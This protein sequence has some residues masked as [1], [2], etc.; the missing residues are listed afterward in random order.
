M[1]YNSQI[2]ELLSTESQVTHTSTFQITM[3]QR[4]TNQKTEAHLTPTSTFYQPEQSSKS[5]SS[6]H[7]PIKIPNIAVMESNNSCRPTRV[8][9]YLW[10]H[11]WSVVSCSAVPMQIC[12]SAM[13]EIT[14]HRRG[15][16]SFSETA[17]E[18]QKNQFQDS[19]TQKNWSQQVWDQQRTISHPGVRIVQ[20]LSIWRHYP[21]SDNLPMGH[22]RHRDPTRQD[23]KKRWNWV[24]LQLLL[25]G[26][27]NRNC[28]LWDLFEKCRCDIQEKGKQKKGSALLS[29][30]RLLLCFWRRIF[31]F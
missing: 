10:V 13:R 12:F 16:T 19:Q 20:R 14:K 24:P 31:P 28:S 9:E 7:V 3:Y 29:Y 30:L 22:R 21:D 25:H 5:V 1:K 23:Y 6:P 8:S 27:G 11:E 17:R 4:C 18:I 15:F 26:K 2:K